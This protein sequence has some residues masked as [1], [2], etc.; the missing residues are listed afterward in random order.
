MCRQAGTGLWLFPP[1]DTSGVPSRFLSAF[2]D[3][4]EISLQTRENR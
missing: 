4:E 1:V 2:P 3:L